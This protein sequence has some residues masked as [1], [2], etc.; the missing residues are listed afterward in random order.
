MHNGQLVWIL[1]REPND[2]LTSGNAATFRVIH[3]RESE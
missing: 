1:M 3:V 2:R